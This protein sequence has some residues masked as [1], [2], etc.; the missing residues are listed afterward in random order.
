MW[1]TV[2]YILPISS[3]AIFMADILSCHIRKS[4]GVNHKMK[5]G[6][7]PL[8][9]FSFR[10]VLLF[11][12]ARRHGLMRHWNR[13]QP[14]LKLLVTHVHWHVEV[15]AVKK[16][17]EEMQLIGM[18]KSVLISDW[19]LWETGEWYFNSNTLIQTSYWLWQNYK[20]KRNFHKPPLQY[21]PPLRL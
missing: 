15:S 7:I 5:D 21:S 3:Q 20:P 13:A 12:L 17:H 6:W 14:L 1:T 2:K 11:L 18:I 8:S 4:K 10:V 9:S 19:L 16:A